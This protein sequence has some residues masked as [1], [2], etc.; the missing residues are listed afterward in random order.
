MLLLKMQKKKKRENWFNSKMRA[1]HH[2]VSANLKEA[3]ETLHVEYF[4]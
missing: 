3:T 2:G 4:E 1:Q